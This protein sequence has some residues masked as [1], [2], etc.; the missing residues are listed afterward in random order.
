MSTIRT[1]SHWRVTIVDDGTQPADASG[2]RP[3]AQLLAVVM[4]GK[5]LTTDPELAERVARLLNGEPQWDTATAYRVYSRWSK[6]GDTSRRAVYDAIK[7]AYA[8]GL[9][10]S[11]PSARTI[12]PQSASEAPGVVESG[13]D[14]SKAA[15]GECDCGHERRRRLPCTDCPGEPATWKAG[16]RADIRRRIA[17]Q[18]EHRPSS[19]GGDGLGY[20]PCV[21]CGQLWPCTTS[22]AERKADQP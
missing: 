21:G 14:G 17:Q 13:S 12:Q 5:V 16:E 6:A 22:R 20:G 15:G 1:G 19:L 18:A 10:S 3:D 11:A 4:A 7:E 9:A 2:H 8:A